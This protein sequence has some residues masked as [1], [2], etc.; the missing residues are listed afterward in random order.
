MEGWQSDWE[1]PPSPAVKK[2]KLTLKPWLPTGTCLL[3]YYCLSIKVALL[4]KEVRGG[5]ALAIGNI[6]IA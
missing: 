1:G 3:F 5:L 6:T 2:K 4:G